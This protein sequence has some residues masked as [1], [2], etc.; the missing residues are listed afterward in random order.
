MKKAHL[1]LIEWGLEKGYT[2]E[3]D[4][5]GEFEYRGDSYKLAKE[6]SEAGD[7]G[8]IT[9]WKDGK[10]AANFSYVHEYTQ[11]PDEIIYDYGVNPVSE[12]WDRDYSLHC[13]NA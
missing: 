2:V 3:V 5:E 7:I 13:E 10:C 12:A 8:G 11:A 1:H 6:A 9:F 4:V